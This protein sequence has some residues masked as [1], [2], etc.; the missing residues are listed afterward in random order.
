MPGSTR[1]VLTHGA[2]S[3]ADFLE[4]SLGAPL[5]ADGWV[6]EWVDDRS[7]SVDQVARAVGRAVGPGV[8]LVGGISLGAHAV[9][10]WAAEQ[11]A[12]PDLVDALVLLLPAWTGPPGGVAGLSAEAASRL[13]QLGVDAALAEVDDGSWVSAELRAA[14][15]TYG[16][17]L[18]PALRATSESPGPTLEALSRIRVPVGVVGLVGDPFHPIEVARAWRDALPW[19]ALVE[20]DQRAPAVGRHVLGHA[21]LTALREATHRKAAGPSGD[22][23][24]SESR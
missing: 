3:T 17:D 1:A 2:G 22:P 13:E 6:P 4:R 10:L 15:P 24:A 21:A 7:G 16:S 9:A 20:L 23:A 19:A 8:G 18:A 11:A 5:R 12:L 14:W